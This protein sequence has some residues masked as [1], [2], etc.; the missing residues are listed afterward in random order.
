MFTQTVQTGMDHTGADN[1]L[2]LGAAADI[3][4]NA[5]W[6][7]MDTEHVLL[8]YFARNRCNM[9]MVSRQK[10]TNGEPQDKKKGLPFCSRPL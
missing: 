1:R 6:F 8:D 9:Y 2:K 4:Q 10:I 3:P 7:Q 5:S